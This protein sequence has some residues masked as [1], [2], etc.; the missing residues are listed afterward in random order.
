MQSKTNTAVAAHNTL[1]AETVFINYSRFMKNC[2]GSFF[3]SIGRKCR[4]EEIEDVFQDVALKI[5]CN[6][7]LERF[8]R[9]R[10]S[11]TTWLGII[12]RTTAID[13]LRRQRG[14]LYDIDEQA[15]PSITNFESRIEPL[16]L[17]PHLLTDRQQ[18]VVELCFLSGLDAGEIASRLGIARKTVRSIKHQA[19][20]RLRHHYAEQERMETNGRLLP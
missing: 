18:E 17:P 16:S 2:I 11:I 7:Y 8:D 20:E 13:H 15:I 4:Q 6:N 3:N 9:S 5:L 10:S 14:D 1:S 12:A 19:L